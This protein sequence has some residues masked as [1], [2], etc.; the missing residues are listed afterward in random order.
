MIEQTELVVT[1]WDYHNPDKPIGSGEKLLSSVW[2]DVMKKRAPTKKG[3]ACRFSCRFIFEDQPLLEYVAEDSYVIDLED[4][5]DKQE[6]LRMI[7]NS[8]SKFK[9][10]FDLRKLGT[11]LEDKTLRPLDESQINLD[12]MLPLVN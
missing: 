12:A 10:R 7:R 8:F 3:I 4:V 6:L 2:L 5:I 11:A 1:T 9:E